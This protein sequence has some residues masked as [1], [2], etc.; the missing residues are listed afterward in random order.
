MTTTRKALNAGIVAP[1]PVYRIY[2]E[3]CLAD[4]AAPVS[5][6]QYGEAAIGYAVAGSCDYRAQNGAIVVVP[7]TVVFGNEGEQF[8]VDHRECASNRR[9]VLR[10]SKP[11]LRAIAEARENECARFKLVGLPPGA[12]ALKLFAQL[13]VAVRGGEEGEEAAINLAE[14]ALATGEERHRAPNIS[15]PNRRRIL[16]AVRYVENAYSNPCTIDTLAAISGLSRYHFIRMFKCV[17]GQSPSC[18]VIQTRLRA[19]ATRL[20]ETKASVS[21]IALDVG[22]NDISHFGAQFRAAFGCTPR[23]MRWNFRE[24]PGQ[25]RVRFET[26]TLPLG[27]VQ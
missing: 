18:Y 15:G 9:L 4:P 6:S 26:V 2:E 14:A 24:R 22:F 13:R 23:Q 19:A 12:N 25:P 21:E 10:F 11:F 8:E 1:S 20:A 5:G 3:Q 17:T 16:S 27:T 7:G